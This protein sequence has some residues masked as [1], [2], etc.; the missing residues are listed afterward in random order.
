MGRYLRSFRRSSPIGSHSTRASSSERID[1]AQYRFGELREP[2]AAFALSH[3]S[4]LVLDLAGQ[5]DAAVDS[6]ITQTGLLRDTDNGKKQRDV[7]RKEHDKARQL[8][9]LLH[10]AMREW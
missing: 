7:A 1:D 6:A 2:L 5:F 10:R 4:P 8:A 3:P 9:G